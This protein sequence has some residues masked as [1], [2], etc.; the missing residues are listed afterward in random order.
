MFA[1][2]RALRTSQGWPSGRLGGAATIHTPLLVATMRP[3][4]W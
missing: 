3:V 2:R 1:A 4:C